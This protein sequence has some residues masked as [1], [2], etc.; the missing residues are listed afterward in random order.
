MNKII[1]ITLNHLRVVCVYSF[2]CAVGMLSVPVAHCQDVVESIPLWQ[3]G[4]PGFEQKKNEPEEAKDWWVKHV[5]NPSLTVYL[6]PKEKAN[7]TAVIVCPGGGHRTLVYNAE[8][9]DAAKFLNNLGVTAFVLKYRLFRE[10]SSVYT[11]EHARQ[12]VFRAMRLVQ[13]KAADYHLDTARIGVMGFSAGGEVAGWLSFG[14]NEAHAAGHDAI[15]ALTAKPDFSILIYPGPLAVPETVSGPLPPVFMLA[16][17]DDSCCSEPVV[18]L[19]SLYRQAKVSAEVHLYAQGGHGFNM[20]Y[21]SQMATL[22]GWPQR[23]A[24]WLADNQWLKK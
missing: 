6:P 22:K 16:A 15:D 18:K 7:G 10:D 11:M 9:A 13:S 2:C 14:Y 12:D 5:N 19:L 20:G 21:R 3:N 1:S 23:L 24:D 8:G 4:A 17:S